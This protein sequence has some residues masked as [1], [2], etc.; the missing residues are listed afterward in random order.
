MYFVMSHGVNKETS[1]YGD[2]LSPPFN[3]IALQT[4]VLP[5]VLFWNSLLSDKP[6]LLLAKDGNI[7]TG[8]DELQTTGLL[9]TALG[10]FVL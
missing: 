1:I 4:I 9:P 8:R 5:P 7:K 6:T 2:W 10:E 3:Y